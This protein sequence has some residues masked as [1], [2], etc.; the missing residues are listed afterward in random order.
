LEDTG[1]LTTGGLL[2]GVLGLDF[3]LAQM[4]Q[5]PPALQ[6]LQAEQLEQAEQGE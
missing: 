5:V 4:P 2:L 6:C 1:G 3:T